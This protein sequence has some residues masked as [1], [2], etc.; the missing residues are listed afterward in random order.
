M[1]MSEEVFDIITSRMRCP[2]LRR[3]SRAA[4]LLLKIYN[5]LQKSV[6]KITEYLNI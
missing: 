4:T 1:S 2:T 6:N 3:P 5:R